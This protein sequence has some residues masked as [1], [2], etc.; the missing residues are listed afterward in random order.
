M[1]VTPGSGDTTL[2]GE[3]GRD[4]RGVEGGGGPWS[5]EG[6]HYQYH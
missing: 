6:T 2:E 1:T 5:G 4:G 3:A